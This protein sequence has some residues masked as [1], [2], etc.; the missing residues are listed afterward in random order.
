MSMGEGLPRGAIL[1]AGRTAAREEPGQS[2]GHW[3]KFPI[4]SPL[5]ALP[6]RESGDALRRCL[7]KQIWEKSRWSCVQVRAAL[8]EYW[9]SPELPRSLGNKGSK[10]FYQHHRYIDQRRTLF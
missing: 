1:V 3:K 4:P 5:T 7:G 6:L 10:W 8:L 2:K 9:R